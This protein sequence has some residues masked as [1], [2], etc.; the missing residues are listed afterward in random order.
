M[1]SYLDLADEDKDSKDWDKRKDN[2]DLNTMASWDPPDVDLTTQVVTD[3]FQ[4][5]LLYSRT[6]QLLLR[7]IA[8]AVYLSEDMIP[9]KDTNTSTTNGESLP[10]TSLASNLIS[11]TSSLQSHWSTCH[12]KSSEIIPLST[13]LPPRAPTTPSLKSYSMSGQVATV[14]DML[15]VATRIQQVQ[16]D[17]QTKDLMVG[18]SY[19]LERSL[20]ELANK[21]GSSSHKL[22]ERGELLEQVIW[23][24]ESVGLSAILCGVVLSLIR[25]GGAGGSKGGKKGKKGKGAVQQ[26]FIDLADSYSNMLMRLQ[27]VASKLLELT[28]KL[29]SSISADSLAEQMSGLLVDAD[30]MLAKEAVEVGKK[31]EKSYTESFYQIKTILKNKQNYL[32]FM[33]L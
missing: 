16:V 23:L 9:V 26:Q 33:R 27:G 6:R 3:S 4:T 2:R 14:L 18:S 30:D 19:H 1:V 22:L 15:G 29:E 24:L 11:L 12:K 5:E 32:S 8:S 28:E 25:G 17:T 20:E 7:T 13:H 31:M 10:S 21:I